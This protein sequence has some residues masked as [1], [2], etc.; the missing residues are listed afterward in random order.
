V[1][2]CYYKEPTEGSKGCVS[3][4]VDGMLAGCRCAADGRRK[5]IASKPCFKT[6]AF[7]SRAG[8][9]RPGGRFH[10]GSDPPVVAAAVK[11]PQATTALAKQVNNLSTL[12]PLLF[13][14]SVYKDLS[15]PRIYLALSQVI[16]KS[17]FFAEC[18]AR[19]RE[20]DTDEE[21]YSAMQREP[22]LATNSSEISEHSIVHPGYYY[23]GSRVRQL[24]SIL[25]LRHIAL[26]LPLQ[27]QRRLRQLPTG[28][29][30]QLRWSRSRSR[31]TWCVCVFADMRCLS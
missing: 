27:L 28:L 10:S 2:A 20:L 4:D 11:S 23:Y 13:S 7:R 19:I 29:R 30:G 31:Y 22:L 15:F 21:K 16:I 25:R 9:G 1:W 5:A 3:D 14:K 18:V 17:A 8:P 24:T 12:P 6:S 26:A